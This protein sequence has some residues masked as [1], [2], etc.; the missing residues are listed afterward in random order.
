MELGP[1]FHPS[2]ILPLRCMSYFELTKRR[3]RGRYELCMRAGFDYPA[4][5]HQ[6]AGSPFTMADRLYSALIIQ[7]CFHIPVWRGD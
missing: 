4:K 5:V 2:S 1:A 3:A 6:P 7:P